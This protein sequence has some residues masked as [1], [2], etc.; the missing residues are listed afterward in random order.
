MTLYFNYLAS[1]REPLALSSML[2]L[3]LHSVDDKTQNLRSDVQARL[4][5]HLLMS[6][7]FNLKSADLFHT[8]AKSWIANETRD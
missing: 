1:P 5:T 4:A 2:V 6:Y 8:S 7:E 3:F